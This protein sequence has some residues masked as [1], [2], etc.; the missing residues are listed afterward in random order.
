MRLFLV[1]FLLLTFSFGAASF[2]QVEY[3]AKQMTVKE[4]A[5]YEQKVVADVNSYTSQGWIIYAINLRCNGTP[6]YIVIKP[7][8]Q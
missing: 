4:M 6:T 8:S 1:A 2:G 3:I 7:K 5:E